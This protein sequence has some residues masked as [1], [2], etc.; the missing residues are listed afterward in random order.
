M[1]QLE[2]DEDIGRIG[3]LP[4][5]SGNSRSMYGSFMVLCVDTHELLGKRVLSKAEFIE[6]YGISGT[7]DECWLSVSQMRSTLDEIEALMNQIISEAVAEAKGQLFVTED[8][9]AFITHNEVRLQNA[10]KFFR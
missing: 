8:G 10:V 9:P 3:L 2:E 4:L 5:R 1:V 7:D 6:I